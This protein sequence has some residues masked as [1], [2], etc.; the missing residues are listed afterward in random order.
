MNAGEDMMERQ[1]FLWKIAIGGAGGVGKTTF[2]LRYLTE[3]FIS[4]TGMTV[5]VQ[6]HSHNLEQDGKHIG[7][8][9]WD[10][11][12][13]E[14]FRF[15]QSSYIKGSVAAILF[16]DTARISTVFE[17]EEWITMVRKY[18]LPDAPIMLVGTKTDIIDDNLRQYAITEG[19]RL[20]DEH[21][22]ESLV[23]TSSKTGENIKE[24]VSRLVD[25]LL[26][27]VSRSIPSESIIAS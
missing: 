25:T 2:M 17:L 27:Q 5:G 1:D 6:F 22:L 20:I 10:L 14:R 9:F 13:Q 8:V 26:G 15:I 12:G 11:G 21:G 4:T 18:A 23:L 19:K 16:F 3:K 24:S 7:M